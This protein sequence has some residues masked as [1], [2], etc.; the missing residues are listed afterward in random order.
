[1]ANGLELRGHF[2]AQITRLYPE[3]AHISPDLLEGIKDRVHFR[4]KLYDAWLHI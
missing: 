2:F 4:L 3:F 1:M